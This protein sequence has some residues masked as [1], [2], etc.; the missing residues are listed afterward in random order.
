MQGMLHTLSSQQQQQQQLAVQLICPN[1]GCREIEHQDPCRASVCTACGT[2]VT[3][4]NS[5]DGCCH[6]VKFDCPLP[7]TDQSFGED[8]NFID[9]LQPHKPAGMGEE[10]FE[11][12]LLQF[13]GYIRTIV[14][15]TLIEKTV[16]SLLVVARRQ[17]GG[18]SV[19]NML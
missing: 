19:D 2:V 6:E 16:I 14:L 7:I 9:S 12:I 8:K 17:R 15:F 1:C 3:I 10:N 13:R 4:V 18:A 5:V 11:N